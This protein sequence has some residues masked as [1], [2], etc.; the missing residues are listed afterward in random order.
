MPAAVFTCALATPFDIVPDTTII[1]AAFS[2]RAR[3]VCSS[4][5]TP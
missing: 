3:T 5:G 1:A 4:F 2:T